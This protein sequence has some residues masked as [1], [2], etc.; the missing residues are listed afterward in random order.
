VYWICL[1]AGTKINSKLKQAKF[2]VVLKSLYLRAKTEVSGLSNFRH[3]YCHEI[4]APGERPL[5][6]ADPANSFYQ[7]PDICF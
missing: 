6:D 7:S 4:M 3:I 2:G 5:V 1:S